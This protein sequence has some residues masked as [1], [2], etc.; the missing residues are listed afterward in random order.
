MLTA[1]PPGKIKLTREDLAAMPQDGKRY[2]IMEGELYVTPSP[3][4]RHQDIVGKLYRLLCRTLY[5]TGMGPVYVA[6]VDV[7]FDEENVVQPDVFFV[8]SQRLDIIQQNYVKGPPD[9]VIEVLSPGTKHRDLKIKSASYA[10]FGVP[11]YWVVDPLAQCIDVY[12]FQDHAFQSVGRFGENDTIEL[13][14]LPG[15]R[16]ENIFI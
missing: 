6:P 3:T 9:L 15:F 8:R 14:G 2:E 10:R 1:I 4:I 5:D 12:L 16:L 13:E 7:V 11:I